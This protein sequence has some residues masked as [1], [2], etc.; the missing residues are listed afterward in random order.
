MS[1]MITGGTGTQNVL[2]ALRVI[3]MADKI[4]L[5]QP[6]AAPL[7]T[8]VS[9]LNK[10]VAINTTIEWPESDLNPSWSALAASATSAATSLTVTTGEGVFF[11]RNDLVK[12]PATGEVMLVTHTAA[13]AIT[14]I[15]GYGS[16]AASAAVGSNMVILGPA[17]EEGSTSTS[18]ITKS[19]RAVRVFNF[20]QLF[21]KSVEVTNSMANV[22]LYGGD[23]RAY[24]R[25]VKG[26]ELMRDLE[27]VFLFGERFED[28]AAGLDPSL[29]HAR[30]TTGGAD[31]FIS[32]NTTA[33]GGILTESD[34][35]AFLRT[36]TRFGGD[37]VY[38]FASPLIISVISQWAQGKLN[39]YPKDKTYGI[40]ISQYLSPLIRCLGRLKQHYMLE[41]PERHKTH[42][43]NI[44]CIGQSARKSIKKQLLGW[45]EFGMEKVVCGLA[46]VRAALT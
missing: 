21:R 14:A 42:G 18:L 8:L 11:N 10:K 20:L 28:T 45:L 35:E 23:I 16:T 29:A 41:H 1:T 3:D 46:L 26:I 33:V 7:Y 6:E 9:R 19:R 36:V 39:M 31:F 34:F 30:R 25:K 44:L 38:L 32:T 5:L 12:I 27:R 22:E 15:R 24:E 4:Y 13:N 40:A 2:Q 17:F 37:E 43:G